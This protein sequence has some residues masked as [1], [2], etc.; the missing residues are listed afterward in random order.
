MQSSIRQTLHCRQRLQQ[1]KITSI[2]IVL[3]ST[4]QIQLFIQE[5]TLYLQTYKQQIHIYSLCLVHLHLISKVQILQFMQE[6]MVLKM[7]CQQQIL[8]LA[9]QSIATDLATA[10]SNLTVS[11]SNVA[12]DLSSANSTLHTRIDA[13]ENDFTTANTVLHGRIDQTN[14]NLSNANTA[15][16]ASIVS[17]E[18]DLGTAN[19][20]IHGRIDDIANDLANATASLNS[21][22]GALSSNTIVK[23]STSMIVD[24]TQA[25]IDVLGNQ[26][27]FDASQVALNSDLNLGFNDIQNVNAIGGPTDKVKEIWVEN[28]YADNLLGITSIATNQIDVATLNVTGEI[29][30]TS[31][32][33]LKTNI[34]P[35]GGALNKVMALQGVKYNWIN[36]E[37]ER[38]EYGLIAENVAE[39]IPNLASFEN[40]K[41]SG[42][43]YS[44]VVALLIEAIKEQQHEIK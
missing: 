37:N 16:S 21:T 8:H 25:V 36:K 26:T 5:S 28:F 33:E 18:S 4:M 34:E 11:I 42:V 22:I 13:F 27:T 43:K 6:L 2:Q 20:T 44:K 31:S 10:N 9:L 29:T 39:I 3:T 32:A 23:S 24:G 38:K 7:T 14:L 15:L 12:T 40:N 35:I 30:E 1:M 41:A 19:T 17:V